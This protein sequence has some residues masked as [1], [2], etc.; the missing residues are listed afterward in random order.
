MLHLLRQSPILRLLISL[1]IGIIAGEFLE[2]NL[3]QS[4][5]LFIAAF[6]I[7]IVLLP[8]R[9]SS[10][11]YR[12]I[13]G[14]SIWLIFFSGGMNAVV[15]NKQLYYPKHFSNYPFEYFVLRITA[16]PVV[17]VK[18]VKTDAE[19][20]SVQVKGE[21]KNV[22]G[23]VRIYFDPK[24]FSGA[25][26]DYMIVK[27]IPQ[28]VAGPLNPYEFNN[29][30]YLS[31]QGIYHQLYVTSDKWKLLPMNETSVIY[32]SSWDLR[33]YLVDILSKELIDPDIYSVASALL[34]GYEEDI[35]DEVMNAYAASGTLHVL[36]V[37]GMHVAL[38]YKVLEWMLSFLLKMKRGRHFY[39][40][41]IIV[42]VWFYSL[43][44]GL[45][46]S[47]LRAAM[48][49]TLVVGGKWMSRTSSVHNSMFVA[50]FFLLIFN[51]FLIFEV[52]FQLS[53][54][55]V[56]GIV[57]IHPLLF[58][59]YTPKGKILFALWSIISV[60]LCATLLTFPIGLFYFHQFP[61]LF[62]ISNMVIIPATTAAIYGCIALVFLY[63]V[64]IVGYIITKVVYWSVWL[65]N[66]AA[67]V[68]EKIP[69]AVAEGIS[70]TYAEVIILYFLILLFV[71]FLL[72]RQASILVSLL[73]GGILFSV[74]QV[75]DNIQI[76]NE[77]EVVVFAVRKRSLCL[78]REGRK[79]WVYSDCQDSTGKCDF[80]M[81]NYLSKNG[82]LIDQ[83]KSSNQIQISESGFYLFAGK[84]IAIVDSLLNTD[85]HSGRINIDVLTVT[86]SYKASLIQLV[87][88]FKPKLVILDGSVK[89]YN[90]RRLLAEAVKQ[91]V[92]CYDVMQS[93]AYIYCL[94]RLK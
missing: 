17:R 54:L 42:F 69:G 76:T 19:V 66:N 86:A 84:R 16:P 92:N 26:G 9:K 3:K 14:A 11:K 50:C 22:E 58:R 55:A 20:V 24:N 94:D 63:K 68:I 65:S 29:A 67:I 62:L 93:G 10:W 77:S 1:C 73:C 70:L 31:H 33:N 37:S 53:L 32:K 7:Y 79:A 88:L 13:K 38:I 46:P 64:P 6:I 78:F 72:K 49:L 25:Y 91:N 44:S 18:S 27:G 23:K 59:I 57:F 12:W 89:Q 52:G 85:A 75:F 81:G 8:K 21:W 56:G 40:A 71:L 82:I 43:L 39:Y 51:P 5:S 15:V 74:F 30:K 90:V 61:N 45:S 87:D 36:S 35:G 80:Q 28:P 34:V 48:M 60:S 4:I 83:L 2:W 41:F 47:V